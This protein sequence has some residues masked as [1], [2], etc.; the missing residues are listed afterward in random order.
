MPAGRADPVGGHQHPRTR[1][2]T[3]IDRIA[4][5]DVDEFL[6]AD[7]AAAEIAHRGE[8]SLESGARKRR[9]GDR[10]LRDIEINFF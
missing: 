8:A 10:M 4:Q 1:H 6:A 7:K 9:R 3:V 2:D 5:G